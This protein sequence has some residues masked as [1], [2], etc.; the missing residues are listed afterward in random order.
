[1]TG[2]TEQ[3]HDEYDNKQYKKRCYCEKCTHSYVEWCKKHK[4][5]AHTMCKR[6]CYTVCEIECQKKQVHVKDW[7][8]NKR[9]DGKWE[10]YHGK[11]HEPEKCSSCKQEKCSCADKKQE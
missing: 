9:Y 3:R 10:P 2:K 5:D 1:M 8:L 7:K 4:E 6:K 11:V